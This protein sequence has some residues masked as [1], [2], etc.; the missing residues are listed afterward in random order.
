M[1]IVMMQ[2]GLL[3]RTG[4]VTAVLTFYSNHGNYGRIFESM[5]AILPTSPPRYGPY[6]RVKPEITGHLQQQ[7]PR[8][9]SE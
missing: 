8:R 2:R 1:M 5:Q 9:V 3:P 4:I 6:F 7:I